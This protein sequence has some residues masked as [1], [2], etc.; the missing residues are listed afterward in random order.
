MCVC[1][2]ACVSVFT[3]VGGGGGGCSM[4]TNNVMVCVPAQHSN[5]TVSCSHLSFDEKVN[6]FKN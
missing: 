1:V 5:G 3:C 4:Y 2:R 6:Q